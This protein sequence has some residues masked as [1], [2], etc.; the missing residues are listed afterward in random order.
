[1]IVAN[2]QWGISTAASTQH[3]EKNI[4]D[5]GKAFNI[6]ARTINGNNVIESYTAIQEAMTYV[7]QERRPF[8]LEAK[9]SRL[10]GHS[11]AS[12]AMLQTH[13]EDPLTVLEQQLIAD[14][15]LTQEKAQAIRSRYEEEFRIM[16]DQVKTEP[17][18]DPASIYDFTYW[19]QT[20][21][22]R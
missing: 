7:R 22:T 18:P 4:A 3:G 16:A 12:G 5:R 10:Y 2:N 13:E 19:Q 15:L 21:A 1:M 20:G 9:V 8:L 14:G 11:S 17:Q 6:K